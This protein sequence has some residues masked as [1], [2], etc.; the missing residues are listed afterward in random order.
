M[1]IIIHL[2]K[3]FFQITRVILG[4]FSLNMSI[5]HSFSSLFVNIVSSR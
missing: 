5:V 4:S 1:S 3:C 2:L